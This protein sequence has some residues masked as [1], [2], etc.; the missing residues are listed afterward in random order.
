LPPGEK[1]SRRKK[2]TEPLGY[3]EKRAAGTRKKVVGEKKEIVK[4]KGGRRAALVKLDLSRKNDNQDWALPARKKK[5]ATE[6]GKSVTVEKKRRTGNTFG[7]KKRGLD[8]GENDAIL[9][10]VSTARKKAGTT[11]YFFLVGEAHKKRRGGGSG[12]GR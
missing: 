8:K 6:R 12:R 7:H 4:E 2:E 5:H 11:R 10:D 1:D 3:R 9:H